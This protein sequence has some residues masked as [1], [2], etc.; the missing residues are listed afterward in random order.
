MVLSVSVWVSTYPSRSPLLMIYG[1]QLTTL[2]H[3]GYVLSDDDELFSHLRL[4]SS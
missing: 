3:N 2:Y 1:A 4:M